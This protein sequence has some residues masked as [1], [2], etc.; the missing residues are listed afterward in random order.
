MCHVNCVNAINST[1]I[2]ALS[3]AWD[4]PYPKRQLMTSDGPARLLV[5][6]VLCVSNVLAT[7]LAPPVKRDLIK[8]A[9]SPS[10]ENG[11]RL[12]RQPSEL[13]VCL[14]PHSKIDVSTSFPTSLNNCSDNYVQHK[15]LQG[16]LMNVTTAKNTIMA[17]FWKDN[18]GW[19]CSD[20]CNRSR[21]SPSPPA[22]WKGGKTTYIN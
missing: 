10:P 22:P 6:R 7:V 19:L 2:L 12:L 9:R 14:E 5:E 3:C 15:K 16:E 13:S 11:A 17:E 8:Q 18:L 20:I 4:S 1:S 21:T